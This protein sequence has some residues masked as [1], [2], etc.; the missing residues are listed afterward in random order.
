MPNRPWVKAAAASGTAPKRAMNAVSVNPISIWLTCPT[1]IGNANAS[2][3]PSSRRMAAAEDTE[4]LCQIAA[5][6]AADRGAARD[7]GPA[8]GSQA[9]RGLGRDVAGQLLPFLES[10]LADLRR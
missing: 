3:G 7:Q 1:V 5:R 2:V 6:T 10:E 8:C 4:R 9:N